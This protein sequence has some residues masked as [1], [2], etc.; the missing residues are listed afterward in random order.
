[1]NYIQRRAL[2]LA[3]LVSLV[4]CSQP[5]T[6]ET[7]VAFGAPGAAPVWAY[8][9]KTGIGSAY[10]AYQD[11]SF[12][13]AQP[14]TGTVSKVWFSLAQGGLTEVMYGLIH[15]AQIKDMQLVVVTDGTAITDRQL[16]ADI[17][18]LTTDS[19]G[20][21][22]APAYRVLN[23]DPQ[24]RFE[25]EKHYFTD[26]A[27]QSLLVRL[28][29]R[30]RQ[31]VAVYA[32]VNPH[33]NNDGWH[34]RAWRSNAGLHS[35]DQ[36]TY[37]TLTA[38]LPFLATSTGFVGRSDG[39]TDLADGHMDWQFASTGQDRGNVALTAQLTDLAAGEQ[40]TL[41]LVLGFGQS[42]TDSQNAARA[43][44]ARGYAKVLIEYR[45]QGPAVGWEDY[46]AQLDQLPRLQ[47]QATDGGA[48]VNASALVLKVQEDKTHAGAL[49]A[50]LSN[51]WGDT[52]SAAEG[53]TGYKAVWPRDFYQCAMA[54]LALGDKATPRVAFEYLQNVQVTDH[55]PGN[56]GTGG[57]FL[58]KTHVD[59]ELEWV[60]VQ[61]D[62]TAMPIMLAWKLWQHRALSRS[63]LARWYPLML[64]PA[65]DFLVDGGQ[66]SLG[67]AQ[68][69]LVPP[70][71]QQERWEEQAGFSPST[72]A[73]VI[74]G[75]IAAAEIAAALDDPTGAT[76]YR[77]AADRYSASLETHTYTRNGPLGDGHYYLRAT[78][79]GNPDTP[80]PLVGRNG[81]G[82]LN[83]LEILD[84]GFLE[85][86]RYGVR[87]ADFP[88]V[89]RSLNALNDLTL[90]DEL[91]V[92]YL[93]TFSGE[94]GEFPGWRRYG[95]DGYGEDAATGGNYGEAGVMR[96]AQR[97]RVWPFLTGEHGHYQLAA[98]MP[99][100]DLRRRY[101]RAMELFANEGLML[102]EQVW[103]GVGANGVHTYQRGEGTNA[104]T[105]LAWTH[106]EYVKLLRSI[107]DQR[108]WDAYPPVARRY[109]SPEVP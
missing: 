87:P 76:R 94:A 23:R 3:V 37:L 28:Q 4:A 1:M 56:R 61:L 74:T 17:A 109:A 38:S 51:P 83:T 106:A 81:K 24:N 11:G 22:T 14:G 85:L 93:F 105:P 31:P 86:V 50:S 52:V 8:A 18:Y 26:P 92:K 33:M 36:G 69:H 72:T 9:G 101:V 80:A 71:T 95:N 97:G 102:P 58:Q 73:A 12:S 55:T 64:K 43:T 19:Q 77:D 27:Q 40:Q 59:G 99:I 84:G 63:A 46:L 104:A 48:L 44:L 7:N 21:P 78:Q 20:R 96:P 25:L 89:Q 15:Q 79:N 29:V 35:E 45:G 75:L 66:L 91:R 65:A 57:W 108:V 62:Q 5:Q 42:L 30:A 82:P 68:P 107:A 13:D 2:T 88:P 67:W 47:A 100:G 32:V 41:D 49:I 16:P 6:A 70:N 103:D 10:E 54:M 60:A 34:D 90:A 98:G 39:I 53:A